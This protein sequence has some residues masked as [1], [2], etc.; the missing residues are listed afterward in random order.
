ML[1]R[2]EGN[3]PPIGLIPYNSVALQI[4]EAC[5]LW[6]DWY[7]VS[8]SSTIDISG[9]GMGDVA[10]LC[11]VTSP[12]S[13]AAECVNAL[14]IDTIPEIISRA[15]YCLSITVH[16]ALAGLVE[17]TWSSYLYWLMYCKW[18]NTNSYPFCEWI[19][20]S[21]F[22]KLS[23]ALLANGAQTSGLFYGDGSILGVKVAGIL[24]IIAWCVIGPSCLEFVPC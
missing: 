4:L 10:A 23:R 3:A 1:L 15:E 16:G 7:G 9:S 13:A 5:I 24:F 18:V 20:A 11:R 22:C 12:L 6:F 2:C 17:V 8:A 14:F 19:A 21:L